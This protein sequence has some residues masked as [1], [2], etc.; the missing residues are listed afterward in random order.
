[1]LADIAYRIVAMRGQ[2]ITHQMP[3]IT[4]QVIHRH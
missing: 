4:Q 3:L 1:M 2:D